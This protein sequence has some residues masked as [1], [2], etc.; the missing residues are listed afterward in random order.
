MSILRR[1]F[2]AAV[3][4][5]IVGASALATTGTAAASVSATAS[6]I[7]TKVAPAPEPIVVASSDF[8]TQAWECP[9]G[10]FCVWENTNGTGRRC[11]WSDADPDWWS[12]SIVC[13]WADDTPVESFLNNGTSTR[14]TGVQAYMSANYQ[15]PAWGCIPRGQPKNVLN[16]GT[17]LRSHQWVTYTC[18]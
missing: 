11:L 6:A 10:N 3:L 2:I 17:K 12:G 9:A 7:T 13:S 14:F 1:T 4:V 16:G 15:N 18:L 8:T 5:G